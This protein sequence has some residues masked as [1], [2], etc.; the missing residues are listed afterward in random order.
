MAI[1]LGCRT[2]LK[3][4]LTLLQASVSYTAGE[5]DKLQGLDEANLHKEELHNK[6]GAP[7]E[8]SRSSSR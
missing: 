5:E 1:S 7:K 6:H 2:A 8:R 3:K 4:E